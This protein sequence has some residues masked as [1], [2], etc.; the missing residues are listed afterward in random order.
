MEVVNKLTNIAKVH[1]ILLLALPALLVL[2]GLLVNLLLQLFLLESFVFFFFRFLGLFCLL[3]LLLCL[4]LSSL[5]LFSLASEF[6]LTL[7]FLFFRESLLLLDNLL[8]L[9]LLKFLLHHLLCQHLRLFFSYLSSLLLC[10]NTGLLLGLLG[11]D[12]LSL[13]FLSFLQFLSQSSFSF[14]NGL[15]L[16]SLL[17]FDQFLL[18]LSFLLECLFSLLFSQLLLS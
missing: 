16:L 6:G 1:G 5:L 8:L 17:L 4:F 2:L 14:G 15:S 11:D 3:L 7:L 13:L 12:F 18:A 10:E 9:I